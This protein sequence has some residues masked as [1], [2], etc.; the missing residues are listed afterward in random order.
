MIPFFN[1]RTMCCA[2]LT[3][4]V[5]ASL[6]VAVSAAGWVDEQQHGIFV[7]RS[8]FPLRDATEVVADLG[9]LQKDI[10]ATL[11]I[12]C[13]SKPIE[14]Y[15]FRNRWAYTSYVRKHVPDGDGRQALFVAGNDVGRVYAYRRPELDTDLR[16]ETTHALLHNAL[17]YVPLWLD[18]GLAEYFENP[19]VLRVDGNAHARNLALALRL[20]GKMNLAELEAK[21]K[22]T[23]MGG[24]EYREAWGWVH[25]LLHGPPEARA[26]LDEFLTTIPTGREPTPLSISLRRRIP[27]VDRRIVEHLR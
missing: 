14:I 1:L 21:R 11:D 3:A 13:Q 26:V 17:P 18:E 6:P 2:I 27:D 15:L 4:L 5:C 8:D 7:F 22:L 25:F 19:A 24:P 16:H 12:R 20:G 9:E 23:E 10:E